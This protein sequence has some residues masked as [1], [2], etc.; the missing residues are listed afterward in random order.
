VESTVAVDHR[1]TNGG[2]GARACLKVSSKSFEVGGDVA[3]D[4][5]PEGARPNK[6]E[7]LETPD[8]H[9]VSLETR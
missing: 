8:D 2:A 1:L 3:A 7:T 6:E 5:V 9:F 4:E